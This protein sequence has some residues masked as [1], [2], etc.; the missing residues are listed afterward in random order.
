MIICRDTEYLFFTL[1]NHPVG[2]LSNFQPVK[3][4]RSDWAWKRVLFPFL[5]HINDYRDGLYRNSCVTGHRCNRRWR[6]QK[7]PGHLPW[8][9]KDVVTVTPVTPLSD[10]PRSVSLYRRRTSPWDTW[11]TDGGTRP[12]YLHPFSPA[13]AVPL[14]SNYWLSFFLSRSQQIYFIE[15]KASHREESSFDSTIAGS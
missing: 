4:N 9:T 13:R 15:L 7:S 8:V 12:Q 5:L 6:V 11:R 10:D 2:C 14:R 3:R 1:K